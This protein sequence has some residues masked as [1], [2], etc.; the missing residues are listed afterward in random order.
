M[1]DLIGHLVQK[2]SKTARGTPVFRGTAS[3]FGMKLHLVFRIRL[4]WQG[5][6]GI[7]YEISLIL[8]KF[9]VSSVAEYVWQEPYTQDRRCGR[10]A[11]ISLESYL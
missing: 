2:H 7:L 8:P 6:A 11:V 1:P 10:R 5:D 3:S 9:S 4:R